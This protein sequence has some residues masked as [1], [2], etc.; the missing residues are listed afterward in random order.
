[1]WLG[2]G[3]VL[4]EPC[5]AILIRSRCLHRWT[6]SVRKHGEI[7]VKRHRQSQ[8]LDPLG[9]RPI[10]LVHLTLSEQRSGGHTK[11]DYTREER[12]FETNTA[13]VSVGLDHDTHIDSAE[14]WA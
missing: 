7:I 11:G 4:T 5:R 3:L 13:L 8:Q 6:R 9:V 1:M 2:P 12:S 10:Q 14:R